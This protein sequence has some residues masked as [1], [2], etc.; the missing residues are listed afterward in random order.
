MLIV[1]LRLGQANNS[2]NELQNHSRS[3]STI[4]VTEKADITSYI[5]W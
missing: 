2:W 1:V 5:S 4:L 3:S